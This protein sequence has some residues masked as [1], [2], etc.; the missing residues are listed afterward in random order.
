VGSALHAVNL[1]SGKDRAIRE[2][3]GGPILAD[4]DGAGLVYAANRYEY[5]PGTRVAFVP[6]ARVEAAV[7]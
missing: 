1:S 2:L 6:L 3:R 4:I 7:S 5:R